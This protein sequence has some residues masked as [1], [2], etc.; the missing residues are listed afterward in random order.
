MG[1]TTCETQ[2]GLAHS[3]FTVR[4]A[5]LPQDEDAF[6]GTLAPFLR[7]SESPIAIACL[8]LVTLPAFPPLPD[9]S[10]LRFSRCNALFTLALAALPY[11][12]IKRLL[13]WI[14]CEPESY[15]DDLALFAA[16]SSA[17]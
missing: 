14:F 15:M 1:A 9:R 3:I 4:Q 10:V 7:A 17:R 13:V 8:R 11:R 16:E 12:A 2:D 5:E 6:R